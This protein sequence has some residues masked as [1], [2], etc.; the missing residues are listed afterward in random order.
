M[1]GDLQVVELLLPFE[2]GLQSTQPDV[3][4]AHKDTPANMDSQTVQSG[5]EVLQQLLDKARIVV[6]LKDLP[7][8]LLQYIEIVFLGS[9]TQRS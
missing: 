6:V 7:Y 2:N 5:A 9:S 4:V 3:N 8:N 1:L